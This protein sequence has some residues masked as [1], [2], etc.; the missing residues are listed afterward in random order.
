MSVPNLKIIDGIKYRKL[1][2]Y[3]YPKQNGCDM[4]CHIEHTQTKN[5]L[6]C[7]ILYKFIFGL[8]FGYKM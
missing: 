3:Q 7:Y 2:I 5:H 1:T 6:I 4:L 8:R